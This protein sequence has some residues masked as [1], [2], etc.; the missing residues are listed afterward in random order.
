MFPAYHVLVSCTFF[1]LTPGFN[2][3]GYSGEGDTYLHRCR[4]DLSATADRGE[5]EAAAEDPP[6]S[7]AQGEGVQQCQVQCVA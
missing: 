6:H 5:P 7:D 3:E 4:Q 2:G 1:L